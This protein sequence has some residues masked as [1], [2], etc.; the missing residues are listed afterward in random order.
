MKPIFGQ[1]GGTPVK[2]CELCLRPMRFLGDYAEY[3]LFR[4]DDCALVSTEWIDAPLPFKGCT[5]AR[6]HRHI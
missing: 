1:G 3:R 4:C 6:P 5:D 2:G